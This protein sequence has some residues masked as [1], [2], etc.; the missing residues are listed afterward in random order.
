MAIPK[1]RALANELRKKIESGV[2]ASGE[3]L[4]TEEELAAAFSVSRQTVRQALDTLVD[5]GL[6]FRRQGSGTY[7]GKQTARRPATRRIGVIATFITDYIFPSLLRGIESTFSANSYSMELVATNNRVETERRVLQDFLAKPIDGLLVEGS[8]TAL[9]NPNIDLYKQIQASGIPIVFYNS[10][11]PSLENI[12]SVTPDEEQGTRILMDYLI[13]K[14]CKKIGAIFKSDDMQ[15]LRRYSTY[16]A[17]CLEAGLTP[18]DDSVFWHTAENKHV[19]LEPMRHAPYTDRLTA[20]DGFL[21]Y[22][23]EVS[24]YLKEMLKSLNVEKMP[25]IASFDNSIIRQAFDV[26]FVSLPHPKDALGSLAA[27]KLLNII[28]GFPEHSEKMQWGAL[29]E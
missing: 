23:D 28:N 2:Y 25:L 7:V 22:N 14:G 19:F 16:Y 17:A 5:D 1:Y 8:K 12:V 29:E 26:P 10:M 20:C 11:Y 18:N 4:Q 13:N 27:K 21:C 6:I 15:G 3:R 9:P 24:F